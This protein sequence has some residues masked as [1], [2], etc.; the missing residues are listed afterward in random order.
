MDFGDLKDDKAIQEKLTNF[1]SS[2]KKIIQMLQL[3]LSSDVYEK[4]SIKEKVE[5]DLFQAYTLSTL[6]WIYLRNKNE[7]PNKNDIKNQL[8][9]IKDCMVKAKQAHERQ[10]IRPRIDQQAAG[11]FVKH[12]IQYK[13]KSKGLPPN[14]KL[15]FSD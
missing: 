5:Y 6:Y 7:D 9:R 10:T 14:K 2:V 13:D 4:L 11:R 3:A 15:K 12:G 8:N 1:Q